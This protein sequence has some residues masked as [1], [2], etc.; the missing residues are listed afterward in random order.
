M[1]RVHISPDPGA[2]ADD[3]GI[4]R[5][6]HAQFARLPAL[7]IELVADPAAADVTACHIEAQG[8]Q[9]DVQHVHGLYWD[10]LPHEP[11]ENWHHLAN[12]R[13]AATARQARAIT[14]PAPWVAECF[15]RD[16]RLRPEVIGHGIDLADWEPIP[17]HKGYA[18]WN[19][20]RATD[21]CD[22]APVAAL[23]RAGLPVV[24]TFAPRQLPQHPQ[25]FVIGARP[26]AEMRRFVTHASLYLATTCETFGVGTLEAMAAGVPVVGYRWGGTAD[27]VTPDAG[28]LVEPGDERALVE[29]AHAA[30]RDRERYSRGARLR[31]EQFTWDVAMARYAALYRRV[32]EEKATE[33][34][35][36]CVVV[37]SYNYARYLPD[38]LRS[39]EAQVDPP[40]EVV[41]V[42]DGS[43]DDTAGVAYEAISRA[44]H[45][46]RYRVIK[47]Q[48]Q[49]VAAA[50]NNGIAST[51][52]EYVICLDADDA[53]APDY[54]RVCRAALQADR[55]LG[56]AY[57]GLGIMQPGGYVTPS[58]F[59]PDFDWERQAEPGNPP[60]TTVPTAAMF[61]RDLW[62]RAGGYKQVHAPGE[63]A[64]LYTRMLSLGATAR[65]VSPD[66]LIHYRNHGE[67]AS[68]TR[69]YRPI[70][71][72]H[73]W[74]R[75][76]RPPFAAPAPRPVPVRSYHRPL[77]SVVI[78]VG[79][80]HARYLPAA[81]DSLL[82]QRWRGW[83][84]IV[85]DDSGEP[86]PE[87]LR[88]GYP[89]VRYV[90]PFD[91]R[92]R[93]G[94]GFARN[95]GADLARAPLLLFLDA[96]DWLLTPDALDRLLAA[97]ADTGAYIYSDWVSFYGDQVTEGQAPEYSQRAWL[98]QGQ[99][100]VTALVPVEWHRDI[101]GF[102]EGIRGWEDW[103]YFIKLA[104]AGHC[105]HRVAQALLG[106]R[107]HTGS[108]RE[109]SLARRDE[110]VPLLRQRYEGRQP[111]GCGCSSNAAA[112]RR[113]REELMGNDLP[114]SVHLQDGQVLLEYTGEAQGSQSV[115]SRHRRN[116]AGRPHRY[117]FGGADRYIAAWAE[118]V[119]FL[120]GLGIFR[121]AGAAA[122]PE[123]PPQLPPA[124]PLPAPA[125][126]PSPAPAAPTAATPAPEPEAAQPVDPAAL[127]GFEQF[128]QAA[129]A[130]AEQKA[131]EAAKTTRARKARGAA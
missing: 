95:R 83:E 63:D 124:A 79:P 108:Q 70:D 91:G 44:A 81:L 31:A 122:A 129:L 29:A 57:T 48:N 17:D 10:D 24:S 130:A 12:R 123:P 88:D 51:A 100:A 111:V 25:L 38:A 71:P 1:T 43:T 94:P 36:V 40:D 114:P 98:E 2:I 47:Q 77:V 84:A 13:I 117:T 109:Q 18:L 90:E 30:L 67:G 52:C 87:T 39:L 89:F 62:R 110:L 4:G 106:Y 115:Q 78:P 126:T 7:G 19:K 96:D 112:L 28:L 68:K 32:A 72:Y 127:A 22:P 53:L 107:Q 65:R 56:I 101:G 80:G 92:G 46:S 37:T 60:R 59:P 26:W 125:P 21:V 93:M 11:Y 73:P 74:M 104:L 27:L 121:P 41:V 50:R 128:Q 33:R 105:G 99:H 20:N 5:I 49:G 69:Q 61:R 55:G 34:H 120:V 42:D 76:G 23:L 118:D 3:N 131:T 102:D 35:R 14:V 15:L 54:I 85:V 116:E 86:W 6:V 75:D 103:D 16:M 8:R 82:S 97:H 119:E 113:I 66:P 9:V 64:E 58:S 45:P